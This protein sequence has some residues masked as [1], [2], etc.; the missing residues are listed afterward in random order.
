M[1]DK[2]TDYLEQVLAHVRWRRARPALREE[3]R[4]HLLEQLEDC[5][6]A[7]MT[8]EDAAAETVRQ[9]GDPAETG[10]ALD[11]LHRPAPQWG[12]LALTVA[13]ALAGGF[14]RVW[15]TA[16]WRWDGSDPLRTAG[17]L[18]LGTVCLLAAYFGDYTTLCRHGRAVYI[19]ILLL[20]ACSLA[21][22][23]NVNGASYYTRYLV[24]FYPLTYALWLCAWRGMGWTGLAASLLGGVPLTALALMAPTVW[25]GVR[26]MAVGLLLL[27]MAV[28]HDWYGVAKK[29]ALTLVCG[30][31]MLLV[32]AVAGLVWTGFGRSRLL[33]ALHPELDPMGSGYQAMMV[34]RA[35]A[36]AR[37]L[38][39]GTMGTAYSGYPYEQIVPEG[40]RSFLLT[41][42]IHQLGW[43]PFLLLMAATAL[44]VVWLLRRGM[45]LKDPMGRTMV[46]AVAAS[47]GLEAAMAAATNLGFVL[48]SATFPLL[49]GNLNTMVHMALIGAA[50]SPLREAHLPAWQHGPAFTPAGAETV[51]AE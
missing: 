26:L 4:E 37:W 33:M 5:R 43:L 38:G 34:R 39:E 7:G 16:G 27:C 22:S 45:R 30:T 41:T 50:L 47:V 32:F 13:L 19:G 12:L 28:C 40:G 48:W 42:A 36:G 20:S 2:L 31:A 15:L 51:S 17:A 25:G 8:E 14:L 21:L 3:L 18:C 35:L 6:A 46:L 29:Q 44:L 49:V 9:M 24:E 10:A 11:G 23:P 1:P